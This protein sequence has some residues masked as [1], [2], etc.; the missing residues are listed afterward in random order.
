M[1]FSQQLMEF[2]THCL[3]ARR[4]LREAQCAKVTKQ[5][6]G[7]LMQQRPR[8]PRTLHKKKATMLSVSVVFCEQ[9]RNTKCKKN[10]FFALS[11]SIVSVSMRT[12]CSTKWARCAKENFLWML[13]SFPRTYMKIGTQHINKKDLPT[14]TAIRLPRSAVL[15]SVRRRGV[16]AWKT[17]Q[18]GNSETRPEPVSILVIIWAVGAG[19]RKI[20]FIT[21]ALSWISCKQQGFII[22]AW[23]VCVLRVMTEIDSKYATTQR[24]LA[25]YHLWV[26]YW[27][28]V[29]RKTQMMLR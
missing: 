25:Y 15:I 26:Q 4:H 13:V 14:A 1:A 3:Q 5:R 12:A 21:S 10:K 22:Q 2:T 7:P 18:P 20:T 23:C 16:L 11:S 8:Q 24:R 17:N 27:Q 9:N 28:R 29:L 6:A 19:A